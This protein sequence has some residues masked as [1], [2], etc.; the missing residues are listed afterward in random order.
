[1][2][3]FRFNAPLCCMLWAMRSIG[4]S[5]EDMDVEDDD[6]DDQL[7]DIS[8]GFVAAVTQWAKVKQPVVINSKA[9]MRVF[10]EEFAPTHYQWLTQMHDS[11]SFFEVLI[12]DEVN[13][14]PG[15]PLAAFMQPQVQDFVSRQA[16][17]CCGEPQFQ[18][19]PGPVLTIPLLQPG[20][21]VLTL[22]LEVQRLFQKK[23][24]LMKCSLMTCLTCENEVEGC[25]GEYQRETTLK[26]KTPSDVIVINVPRKTFNR[27]TNTFGKNEAN[28]QLGGNIL[29]PLANGGAQ[30]Y[31]LLA[32]VEHTGML[33]TQY[34]IS[35]F[36][37]Q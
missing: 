32:A 2:H 11:E 8:Q 4:G 28:I 17:P 36:P 18:N 12:K 26:L 34:Q 19:R 1:M 3:D 37:L 9:V 15:C 23:T 25:R 10:I 13:N 35:V 24:E 31:S 33:K 16:C 21:P 29:I 7:P 6:Q 30:E 27:T 22:C 5:T 14:H 20:F